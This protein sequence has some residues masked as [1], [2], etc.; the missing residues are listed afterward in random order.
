MAFLDKGEREQVQEILKG[1]QGPV[2]LL[3]FTHQGECKAC[4]ETRELL[5]EVAQL[6]D[7][8]SFEPYDLDQDGEKAEALGIDKAPAVAIIGQRD[9]GLRFY[10]LPTGYEFG[11][12][13][14]DLVDASKGEVDLG[15]KTRE[16]LADLAT[17][18]HIQVFTTPG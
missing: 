8:V 17:P 18:V 7:Q 1:L 5:E 13:L 6:A 16:Y 14:E 15:K 4:N 2:S 3:V 9:F 11:A 12:L 10:G